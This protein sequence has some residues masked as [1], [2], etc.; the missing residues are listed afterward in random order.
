[1]RRSS[2]SLLWLIGVVVCLAG[3]CLAF[4]NPVVSKETETSSKVKDLQKERL[5]VLQ[6]IYDLTKKGFNDGVVSY[7]QLRTSKSD[8]LSARVDYADAKTDKI[9]ACDEAVEDAKNWQKIV[10]DGVKS[11]VFSRFDDLK[12]QSD[13]LDAQITR[14]NADDDE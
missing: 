6:S 11:N 10:Q 7:E 13:L 1:M 14:E 8:L 9:K 3:L 4:N 5:A 12:T 2:K